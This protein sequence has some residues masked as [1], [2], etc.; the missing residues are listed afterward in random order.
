[1]VAELV[2]S[3]ARH[4]YADRA[5]AFTREMCEAYAYAIIA[6]G[7]RTTATA[8]KCLLQVLP[9]CRK[10]SQ[11]TRQQVANLVE[12]RP[13]T[14]AIFAQV[15]QT[16]WAKKAMTAAE[17]RAMLADVARTPMD[18]VADE[19]GREKPDLTE[20]ERLCIKKMKVRSFTRE[21]GTTETTH[22]I[23]MYDRI[24]AIEL[25][26]KLDPS[27]DLGLTT[28]GGRPCIILNLF[29]DSPANA[30][31]AAAA[32]PLPA[33]EIGNGTNGNGNGNGAHH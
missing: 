23:E 2:Y 10:W 27:S 33:L 19:L 14:R 29:G 16:E 8:E 26:A 11:T 25:D 30:I 13:E 24:Q 4:P 28:D 32:I 15:A 7:K 17:R 22:E 1:M 5:A 6:H 31:H 9:T 18:C 21:D 3:R 12:Q 20:A